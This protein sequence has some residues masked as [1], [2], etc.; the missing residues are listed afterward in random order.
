MGSGRCAARFNAFALIRK[1]GQKQRFVD[2]QG[3]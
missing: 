2:T 1:D 3:G